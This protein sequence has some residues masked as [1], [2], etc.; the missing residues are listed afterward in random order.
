MN[1]FPW[2]SYFLLASLK[3]FMDLFPRRSYFLVA[4]LNYLIN[5][6]PRRS[7]FLLASLNCLM[8]LFPR[9]SAYLRIT[10]SRITYLA[11]QA[12]FTAYHV[13]RIT[14]NSPRITYQRI[15]VLRIDVSTYL[16][17]AYR[18]INVFTYRGNTFLE[19]FGD[20]NRK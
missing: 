13:S 6:F 3:Y 18:R 16:R 9:V 2:R 1:L 14:P 8:N 15:Y 4:S 20:A 17:I 11:H 7:Y 10:Y 19:Y 5:L 12:R